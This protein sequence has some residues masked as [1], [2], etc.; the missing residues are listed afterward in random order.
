[1]G[2]FIETLSLYRKLTKLKK[3]FYLPI[4]W[5]PI[6]FVLVQP[7][8]APKHFRQPSGFG[9][10]VVWFSGTSR[11]HRSMAISPGWYYQD[12][13]LNRTWS[14]SNRRLVVRKLNIQPRADYRFTC[15]HNI[16]DDL[17]VD[18][19]VHT[20]TAE[21]VGGWTWISNPNS[22]HRFARQTRRFP[23]KNWR[24]IIFFHFFFSLV[25]LSSVNI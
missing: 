1:M 9:Q 21:V 16:P 3:S 4:S 7:S 23:M 5:G 20:S 13:W 10:S 22:L 17:S 12:A 15:K 25:R 19:I 24:N 14:D 6:D 18:I 8:A 11:R 2:V